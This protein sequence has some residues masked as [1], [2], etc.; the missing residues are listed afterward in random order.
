MVGV[1]REFVAIAT[2]FRRTADGIGP[3]LVPH[4]L[5]A[6]IGPFHASDWIKFMDS[7][8]IVADTSDS[9]VSRSCTKCCST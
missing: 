7:L 5:Q 9:S 6:Y 8:N 2:I 4:S 3:K 1:I